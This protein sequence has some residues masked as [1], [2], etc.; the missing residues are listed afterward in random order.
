MLG[1]LEVL[2]RGAKRETSVKYLKRTKGCSSKKATWPTA[3]MK[4]LYTSAQS[5]GNKQELEATMLLES[6][7]LA[8]IPETLWDQSRD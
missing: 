1:T 6:Y 5:M 7:N 2:Q 3:Q 8:D 4:C